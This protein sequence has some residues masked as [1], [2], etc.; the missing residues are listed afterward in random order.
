MK[1]TLLTEALFKM[2]PDKAFSLCSLCSS[3]TRSP[4]SIP[5]MDPK[6]LL[7]ADRRI[8]RCDAWYGAL[9]LRLLLALLLRLLLTRLSAAK[10]GRK[11]GI[12]QSV[13]QSVSQWIKMEEMNEWMNMRTNEW[14]NKWV[15]DSL[16]GRR[17]EGKGKWEFGRASAHEGERKGTSSLARGLAPSITFPFPFERLPRR[18]DERV[19]EWTSQR[20]NEWS[21]WMNNLQKSKRRKLTRMF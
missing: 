12:S 17:W 8:P 13:S 14:M 10:K 9:L 18:L 19:H 1:V 3:S 16:R 21:E 20:M 2:F 5:A 4:W 7:E 15:K 11:K 6:L